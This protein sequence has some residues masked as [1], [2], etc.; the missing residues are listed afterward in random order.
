MLLLVLIAGPMEYLKDNNPKINSEMVKTSEFL[1][2]KD[3][4]VV[5]VGCCVTVQCVW[6]A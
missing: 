5:A 2:K 4:P 3:C 6:L 1:L